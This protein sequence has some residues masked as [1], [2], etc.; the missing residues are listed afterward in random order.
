MEIGGVTSL[1]NVEKLVNEKTEKKRDELD[2]IIAQH[3]S[4]LAQHESRC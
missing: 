4:L 2:L 3:E 1:Q